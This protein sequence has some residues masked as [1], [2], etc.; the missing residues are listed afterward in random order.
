MECTVR[1]TTPDQPVFV[2]EPI[3]EK[4]SD[5]VAGRGPVIMAIDNLPAEISLES[6]ISFSNSLK[7]FIPPLAEAD[8]SGDFSSCHLPEPIK[9]AVILY[10]GGFTPCFEYMREFIN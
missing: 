10:K 1:A 9:K 8:F 6:S 2:Y 5:G 4:A 3:E 7:P